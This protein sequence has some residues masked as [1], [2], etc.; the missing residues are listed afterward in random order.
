MDRLLFILL[1]VLTA[2]NGSAG[3]VI[4]ADKATLRP[5]PSAS[6]F[7]INGTVIGMSDKKGRLPRIAPTN[8]PVTIRYLGYMEKTV[9]SLPA[10]TLFLNES[11]MELPEVVVESRQ[12]KMMHMLAYVR[13]YSTLS[14]YFDTVFLFREKMVD[15]MLPTDGRTR[16]KGWR[17]PRIIKSKSYYRFRNAA[18]LDSV[19]SRC[20]NHFSWSDWIGITTPP[21]LPRG[22][23]HAG[24]ATDTVRG[25]YADTEIW[26]RKDDR[27]TVDIDVLADTS[28]RKWIPQLSAFFR[29]NI[30]FD[31]FRLR[32]SYGDVTADTVGAADLTGYSFNVDSR[33]R[34]HNMFRFNR[35]DEPFFVSTFAEIHI[36]DKE[37]VTIG[38]AKKWE[39]GNFD[40]DGIEIITPDGAPPLQPDILALIGRVDAINHDAVR[41]NFTPDSRLAGGIRR[42][43]N[44]GQRALAMLKQMT[45]IT[46]FKSHKK[47][48]DN[49]KRFRNL[50]GSTD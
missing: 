5:L 2:A 16:Y 22:V 13:E 28:S 21:S 50:A 34:G 26:I 43:Q 11:P 31:N 25:K 36:L 29:N 30:D 45:G 8:F 1:T 4:V 7:S 19:S 3:T 37:Y 12:Q 44:I 40:A 49:L 42:P 33:G 14:T 35:K 32:I 48:K 15:Y 20:N 24:I 47:A 46:L 10:D 38:E 27:L 18:G 6:V 39:K 17:Y 23:R 9:D 41:L